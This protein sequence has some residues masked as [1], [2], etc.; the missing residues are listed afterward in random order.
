MADLQLPE[1]RLPHARGR[2]ARTPAIAQGRDWILL[3]C[4]LRSNICMYIYINIYI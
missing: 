1:R 2:A 4:R 3:Y